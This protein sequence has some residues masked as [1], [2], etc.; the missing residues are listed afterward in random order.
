[1]RLAVYMGGFLGESPGMKA[2]LFLG[3]LLVS[4]VL[5]FCFGRR[6]DRPPRLESTAVQWS[7]VN[8]LVLAEASALAYD[9]SAAE[10]IARALRCESC[11]ILKC[12]VNLPKKF[13]FEQGEPGPQGFIAAGEEH[14]VIAF[15]GTEINLVDLLT[16]AWAEPVALSTKVAGRVHG[17]FA[18]TFQGLWPELKTIL[19]AQR[20][21]FPKAKLWITGHSLGGA[22][23]VMAAAVIAMEQKVPVQGMITFGTPVTGDAEFHQ[24]L[25]GALGERSWRVVHELDF[26]CLDLSALALPFVNPPGSL[27]RFQHGGRPVYLNADGS[28]AS[29]G[30]AAMRREVRGVAAKWIRR[31]FEPPSGFSARHGI[32]SGYLPALR[33]LNGKR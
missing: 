9:S 4:G 2:R 15:R 29:E 17:G 5:L 27:T 20:T 19:A 25:Q 26:F 31:D 7:P 12:P 24:A 23:A 13:R 3:F 22:L 8:A 14:I 10:K 11:Q 30:A 18:M 28:L 21:R 1:M 33:R 16:D 6:A 32:G